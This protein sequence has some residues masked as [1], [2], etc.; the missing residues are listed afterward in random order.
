MRR[1]RISEVRMAIDGIIEIRINAAVAINC[2]NRCP[3]V[4]L[5]VSRTPR[6]KGRI[7]K[8]IVSIIMRI[9]TNIV[10]VPS[11]KKW[12]RAIVGWLSIPINTVVNQRGRANAIF[13]ESWVVGVNVYGSRPRRLIVIRNSI[14]AVRIEAH[15]CPPIF[16][17]CIS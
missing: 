16:N 4:R 17:G 9:G 7:N 2:I 5:A 10:G 14:S 1:N 13:R 6:A 12:P 3:A 11:G 15:L 8:L